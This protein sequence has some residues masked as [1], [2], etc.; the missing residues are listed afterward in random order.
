MA[1]N[2]LEAVEILLVEDSDAD[3]EMTIR[4]LKKRNLANKLVWVK[5]G[6][7]ALD[8]LAC[9]GTFAE[10]P[11]GRPRLILL[12]IKMPKVDGIEVL[13]QIKQDE[14]YR[15]IPVV[16]LTSSAEERDM[17]ESYRLGVNSYLVK[18]VDFADF[19]DV[20]LQ[21]GLYWAVMNKV[22]NC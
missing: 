13:R 5:D 6:A 18:P 8:F 10:R 14:K 4:A 19:I 17:I 16:M 15:T 11:R 3:A 7:E 9:A 22:P 12:D 1:M 21:A 2:E 20:V